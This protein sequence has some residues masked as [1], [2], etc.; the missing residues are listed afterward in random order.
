MTVNEHDIKEEMAEILPHSLYYESAVKSVHWLN[1]KRIEHCLELAGD[2]AGKRILDAGTGDGYMLREIRC[3]ELWGIDI[4]LKRL[5]R[6]AQKA[7]HAI[8]KQDDLNHSK[9]KSNYF[10]GI[11]CADVLEHMRTPANAIHEMIRI[12]KPD[13]F[14]VLC[15]PQEVNNII[16]RM[17]LW[18][19]PIINP[20]HY[21]LVTGFF[22]K[23]E[24]KI[25]PS[26]VKNIPD[27]PGLFCIHRVM[28]YEMVRYGKEK[29][30]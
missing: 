26:R 22:L 24:F 15:L 9:L 20:D 27:V 8:L 11:I 30:Y 21:R 12:C 5:E 16:A 29:P 28:R 4:S 3:G 6:A 14:I 2:M 18:K 13:G 23:R 19:P 17:I 10:D 25:R 1:Y 7:P